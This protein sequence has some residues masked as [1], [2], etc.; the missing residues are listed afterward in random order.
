MKHTMIVTALILTACQG[1]QGDRGGQGAVGAPGQ[2]IIGPVGATGPSGAPGLN[3]SNGLNGTNGT[4]GTQVD[5]VQFCPGSTNYASEFNE[6][7]YCINGQIYAV[8]SAN[9]GFLSLIPPGTYSSNGINS[10]CSF[11]VGPN[12]EVT[13]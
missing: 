12:C 2:T 1:P 8:Y 10:S 11:V 3:G 6:V 13:N 7:G 4:P 5:I 9:D